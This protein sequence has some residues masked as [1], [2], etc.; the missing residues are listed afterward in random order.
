MSVLLGS[1]LDNMSNIDRAIEVLTIRVSWKARWGIASCSHFSPETLL[2]KCK[3]CPVTIFFFFFV[4]FTCEKLYCVRKWH[5]TCKVRFCSRFTVL[6]TDLPVVYT[7]W[8][9][10]HSDFGLLQILDVFSDFG[11]TASL[12]CGNALVMKTLFYLHGSE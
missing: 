3:C 11:A 9:S 10:L 1:E 12:P 4:K 6:S 5:F 2:A 7:C 8:S